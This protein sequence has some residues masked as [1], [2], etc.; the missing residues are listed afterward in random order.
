MDL[1][2]QI[3][4]YSI[5]ALVFHDYFKI[6]DCNPRLISGIQ[7]RMIKP[8]KKALGVFFYILTFILPFV[9]EAQVR[10]IRGS[11]INEENLEPVAF[12]HIAIIGTNEG[13]ISNENGIFELKNVSAQSIQ[14]KVSSIGYETDTVQWN[15]NVGSWELS[16]LLTP[17]VLALNDVF[18]ESKK[19][20]PEEII[21]EAFSRISKNYWLDEHLLTGYFKETENTNGEPLYIAE[22]IIQVKIPG[23]GSDA[24]ERIE[25]IHLADRKKDLPN[26]EKND[27]DY[28]TGGAYRCLKNS[29]N[30]P[31]NPVYPSHF[32]NYTYKI[33]GYTLFN[34]KKVVIISFT[35]SKRKPIYGKL[36]IDLESY[37]FV[38]M[39]GT[40]THGDGSPFDRWK[41]TRHTWIEQYMEDENGKWLLNSSIYLGDWLKK[42]SMFY[43]IMMSKNQRYQLRSFYYTTSY[44]KDKEFTEKGIKFTRDEEFYNREFNNDETY[45]NSFN[46]LV[47]NEIEKKILNNVEEDNGQN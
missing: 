20:T 15:T 1:S 33:E 27:L 25:I 41:W 24:D 9:L 16:I 43:W 17:S 45:W 30:D 11:L 40:K 34:G 26:L 8:S 35:D 19:V 3:G 29:I 31:I 22:A 7:T 2:F 6:P 4:I 14:I 44:S 36:I 37:A 18:I 28:R 42:R 5:S 46:Y 23:E 10:S 32:K 38:R 39:E 12:A 21:K 47:P 13:T